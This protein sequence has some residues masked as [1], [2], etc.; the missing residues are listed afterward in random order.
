MSSSDIGGF[1]KLVMLTTSNDGTQEI[2]VTEKKLLLPSNLKLAEIVEGI[3]L[4]VKKIQ[5]SY[6][7]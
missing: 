6:F 2:S 5:K 4:V 1:K 7:N 3:N